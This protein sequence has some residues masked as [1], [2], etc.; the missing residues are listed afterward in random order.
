[1]AIHD[2][3]FGTSRSSSSERAIRARGEQM[4]MSKRSRKHVLVETKS[5]GRQVR[6][7]LA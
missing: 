1:M 2:R 7:Y 6:L 3:I 5:Y 4:T